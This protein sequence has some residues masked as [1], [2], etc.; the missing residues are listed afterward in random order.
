MDFLRPFGPALG[1]D[2]VGQSII[3]RLNAYAD[4][5]MADERL[6]KEHDHSMHLA[7][8]VKSEITV[9]EDFYQKNPD[10]RDFLLES[11]Y[12]YFEKVNK[13]PGPA[14]LV[15]TSWVVSQ[16]AGDF[17]PL[18][19]H[20]GQLSGVMYL[21]MPPDIEQEAMQ[22]D[23]HPTVGH[24]GFYHGTAAPFSPHEFKFLPRV[25]EMYLFPCHLL[26]CVYPFRSAGERRS[27]SFN[28]DKV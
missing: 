8:N 11:A 16:W 6:L 26:H 22:E 28:L 2:V 25:G 3:D 5:V 12:R 14:L 27:F 10:I 1:R 18:H 20:Y 23:H 17:N 7:G 15:K 21:R 24:I 9:T 13:G 19:L 4:T